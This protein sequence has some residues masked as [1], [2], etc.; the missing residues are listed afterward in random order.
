ML[1][2]GHAANALPQSAT[3]TV[4]CRI[5]PGVAVATVQHSLEQIAGPGIEVKVSGNVIW[6][7]ASPLRDDVVAAVTRAVRQRYPG[8]PVAPLQESSATDGAVFR[9]VGIPTY[10]VAEWFLRRSEFLAHGRDERN[11]VRSFYDG[12]EQ[13]YVLLKDLAGP[14]R[15][16]RK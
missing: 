4:N 11:S 13:W 12:I 6:S 10:G 14:P 7:D 1:R 15:G 2:G 8:I 3:A 9:G 16:K 5:F